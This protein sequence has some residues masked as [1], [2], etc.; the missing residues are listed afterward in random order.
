M[1]YSSKRR[2]SLSTESKS[3]LINH[4]KIETAQ[5]TANDEDKLLEFVLTTDTFERSDLDI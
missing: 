1:D 5:K 4:C 3:H 2:K